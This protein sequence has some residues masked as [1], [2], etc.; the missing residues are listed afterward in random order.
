MQPKYHAR[1]SRLAAV[2]AI[3]ISLSKQRDLIRFTFF[4]NDA[5]IEDRGPTK[6]S[7]GAETQSRSWNV[8]SFRDDSRWQENEMTLSSF[9]QGRFD[10]LS[11]QASAARR[12]RVAYLEISDTAWMGRLN[13]KC[14]YIVQ[15]NRIANGIHAA[16]RVASLPRQHCAIQFVI[17]AMCPVRLRYPSLR[18]SGLRNGERCFISQE[19]SG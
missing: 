10:L 9:Q 13:G 12:P 3:S 16:A 15:R 6:P 8:L 1:V 11:G 14:Q 17:H 2:A 7:P 4:N 18:Y 5:N 19:P